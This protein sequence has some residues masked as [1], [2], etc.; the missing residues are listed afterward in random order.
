MSENLKKPEDQGWF[1]YL[2]E[3][4]LW[5]TRLI[6][7]LAVLCSIAAAIVLFIV[8]SVD[9]FNE[10]V[11]YFS[12]AFSH[13]ETSGY[14]HGVKK[15][16]HTVLLMTIIGSID[17]YLIGVVLIIFGFGIYELFISKLDI[18][19]RYT[20]ITILE[21]ENLDELKNRI[22]KVIIMVLIVSFFKKVLT[23]LQD[24]SAVYSNPES[25]MYL[26]FSILALAIAVFL[27]NKHEAKQKPSVIQKK[28]K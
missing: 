21:I 8:G 10:V 16:D 12:E 23:L 5:Q 3:T 2:L 19:R 22:V 15:H 13:A 17:L 6:V 24:G 1:E 18:A 9:I 27:L 20:E 26:A 14:E 11:K 28:S 4:G 25:M 7:L